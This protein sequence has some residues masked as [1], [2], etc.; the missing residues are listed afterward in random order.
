MDIYSKARKVLQDLNFDFSTFTLEGFLQAA[1][2]LKDRKIE[3][4]PCNLPPDVL[5]IWL[6][7]EA[8]PVE[9]ISYQKG[10]PEIQQ[11]HVQLHEVSH[12][13]MGHKTH[14]INRQAMI[15][16]AGQGDVSFL[17]EITQLR[18]SQTTTWEMEAETLSSMIQKHVIRH[19]RLGL[20]TYHNAPA[21]ELA[22]FLRE[23]GK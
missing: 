18:S 12:F 14:R 7:D 1:G 19:S 3:V 6:T 5:G 17:D 9:Y 16:A 20:L 11:I 22:N 10:L 13:L 15:E 23:M 4:V 2:R 8:E 21:G